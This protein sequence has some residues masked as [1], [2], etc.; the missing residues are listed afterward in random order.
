MLYQE[1]LFTEDECDKLIQYRYK[2]KDYRDNGGYTNRK[3]INYKQWTIKRTDNLDYLFNR[4]IEFIEIKFK[5]IINE[6][7]EDS[8]IYQ[9]EINDGYLMHT[10]NVYDR[11]FTVGVQLNNDYTG[12]DLM[13]DC[14][15]ERIIVNK[16]IGNCYIFESF[17]LHGVSPILCGNRFNFLTFI[18]NRNI[19]YSNK[20][21]I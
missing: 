19:K 3:D 6:F 7:N 15:K 16:D 11:R 2:L 13:V 20:T 10:D 1:I 21:L 17:L 8:W 9:Y 14:G 18:L 4:I 5:V 12:G